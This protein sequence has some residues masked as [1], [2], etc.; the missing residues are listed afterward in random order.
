MKKN[1]IPFDLMKLDTSPPGY[2]N[3]MRVRSQIWEFYF[4]IL[5]LKSN[6]TNKSLLWV[7]SNIIQEYCGYKQTSSKYWLYL[8]GKE[9]HLESFSIQCDDKW[10]LTLAFYSNAALGYRKSRLMHWTSP[11]YSLDVIYNPHYQLCCL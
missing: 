8:D 6:P 9:Q 7:V 2:T 11:N 1:T 3:P 5:Y 10:Y 4:I